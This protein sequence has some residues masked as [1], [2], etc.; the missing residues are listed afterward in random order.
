MDQLIAARWVVPVVPRGEVLSAHAVALAGDT[1]VDVL[2]TEE[3]RRR[4]S[5][6]EQ[7]MELD[8]HVLIPGLVNAHTHAAMSLMRGIADDLPLMQWLNE[9]IWPIEAAHVSPEF[10]LDGCLLAAREMLAGGVTMCNDMYFH[11]EAAAQAFSAA[12]MRA[13]LGMILIDFPTT[14]AS[15][16]DEYLAKGVATRDRWRD[17]PLL[18]FALAPHAPYTA[19]D[20]TLSM[21]LAMAA[22]IDAPI[23]IHVHETAQE[24][25]DSVREHG[26]RPIARLESLGLLGTSFVG[27]HAVHLDQDEISRLGRHGCS[28][29]HCPVSNMKLASGIAPVS[30]LLAEGVNVALGTD[31]AASNNRL[32]MF[33][34]MRMAALLAKVSSAD[35]SVVTAAEALEMATL[36]GARALGMDAKIGSLEAGKLADMCA[37]RLDSPQ[38]QPC[39]DPLAQLVYV[40]GREHVDA[41]WV[42][43]QL[44]VRG[45]KPLLFRRDTELLGN[46]AV[47]QSRLQK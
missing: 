1:I 3:A 10:V 8:Q 47:W 36:N 22:E 38:T 16:P 23:H 42:G 28:V 7:F 25:A 43:G 45:G 24:V 19:G 41:V 2:P 9:A 6:V 11:P 12:G 31:G 39:F 17:E 30:R 18:S 13:M 15:G 14:Y 34:E 46:V 20:E 26:V 40:C 5:D 4:Y 21:A 37:V 33:G 35:A 27:V 32:D 29:V 44:R